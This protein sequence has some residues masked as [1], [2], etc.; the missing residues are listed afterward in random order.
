MRLVHTA[1]PDTA[2]QLPEVAVR[3]ERQKLA[4]RLWRTA[5]EDGTEFGYD[6]MAPVRDGDLLAQVQ[7]VRYVVRQTAEPLLE[8]A[9]GAP[10][11]AAAVGWAVG[12]LH[13]EIELQPGRLLAPDDPAL[14]QAFERLGIAYRYA[15]AVF[16]PHRLAGQAAGHG[17]R[18]G[19]DFPAHAH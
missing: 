1:L 10:E 7:G 15:V 8:V 3:L 2:P 11:E 13:F 14:R 12:N 16:R 4:K 19:E 17:H 5:A 18:H 9:F 6:G